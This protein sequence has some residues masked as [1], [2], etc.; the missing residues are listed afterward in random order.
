VIAPNGNEYIEPTTRARLALV[1][2]VALAIAFAL[3]A[4]LVGPNVKAY[5]QQ[6]PPCELLDGLR[7][8]LHATVTATVCASFSLFWVGLRIL[9][10][11]QV[12]L[13]GSWVVR[14]TRVV[15]DSRARW[16]ARLLMLC[17][18]GV[19]VAAVVLFVVGKGLLAEFSP[20]LH[21]ALP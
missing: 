11:G 21:C 8:G 9:Q 18:L 20:R 15:R 16:L 10:H 7:W 6:L 5:L 14:R 3:A 4:A 19:A 12:P 17:G 1:C 2:V 13:P